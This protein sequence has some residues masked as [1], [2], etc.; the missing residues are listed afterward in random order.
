MYI[1]LH[2]GYCFFCV[3]GIRTRSL[4]VYDSQHFSNNILQNLGQETGE[5]AL[6]LAFYESDRNNFKEAEAFANDAMQ[7]PGQVIFTH[8]AFLLPCTH[9]WLVR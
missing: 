6:F 3:D 1:Y 4:L 7:Y 5:S 8:S 2:S 9:R